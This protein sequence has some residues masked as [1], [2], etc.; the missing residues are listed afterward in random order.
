MGSPAGQMS[1]QSTHRPGWFFAGIDVTVTLLLWAYFTVGFLVLF[2]P[3]YLVAAIVAT[4]RRQAFQRLTHYFYRGFFLLCRLLIPRHTWRIDNAVGAIRSSVIV[5]NHVSYI[6]PLLLIALYPHHTTIVKSRLFHLPIFGWMLTLSGYLPSTTEGRLAGLMIQRMDTLAGD[7][8]RGANLFVFPEG[9]RSRTGAIGPFHPGAFK[10]A[11]L[12]RA[13][14][15]VLFIRHTDRLFKPGQFRF[16]T[17]CTNTISVEL[18]AH[19]T[20][21][22]DDPGFSIDNLMEEVRG[23]MEGKIS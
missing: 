2:L 11:R 22:Y 1:V 10:I 21:S 14:V 8:A 23:L 3:F 12:C 17:C 16:N 15:S 13:P 7:L 20:P 5:C 9:T 4:R 19:L 6:D 18:L